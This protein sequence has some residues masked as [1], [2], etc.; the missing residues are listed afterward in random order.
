MF[1][2]L[3]AH[4]KIYTGLMWILK[5]IHKF[6]VNFT[7]QYNDN[8]GNPYSD[9]YWL[10]TMVQAIGELEFGQQVGLIYF[11]EIMILVICNF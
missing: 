5:T 2:I 10:A 9:V 8:N 6:N 11:P 7:L 3:E 4:T 1:F